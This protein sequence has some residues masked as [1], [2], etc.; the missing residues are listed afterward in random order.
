MTSV[1]VH[2]SASDVDIVPGEWVTTIDAIHR[3][4]N[5]IAE[6]RR[7]ATPNFDPSFGEQPPA[8]LAPSEEEL[9]IFLKHQ[10][11]V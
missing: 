3:M 10:K 6:L 4:Q 9:G 2:V 5:A 11:G 8:I 7:M 1:F